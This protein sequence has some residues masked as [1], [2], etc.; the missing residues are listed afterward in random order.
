MFKRILVPFDGSESSARAL[1]TA[2]DLAR[3]SGGFLRVIH[4]LEDLSYV[5]AF[6]PSAAG[7]GELSRVMREAGQR[8]LAEST[9][10]ARAA[11]IEADNMLLDRH[12]RR[13]GDAIAEAA[14]L[15]N[16]DLIVV[17]THGRR[18]VARAVLGS[19]AEQVIRMAP[20]PVLVVRHPGEEA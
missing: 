20:V 14:K 19:G 7:A 3:S 17:G 1:A 6:E 8:L 5:A 13:L 11:G 10:T 12:G 4:Q 18:G 16:A 9:A 15:W 2:I